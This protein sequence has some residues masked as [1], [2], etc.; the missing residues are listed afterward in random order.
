K[1][2]PLFLLLVLSAPPARAQLIADTLLTWEGYGRISTCRIQIFQSAPDEKRPLTIVLDELQSNEGETTLNDAQHIVELASRRF[3]VDPEGAFWIF[4]WGAFSFAGAAESK[5]EFF[6]RA[7]FRRTDSGAVGP[8]FWRLVN[9][10]TV[11]EYTDRI[12]R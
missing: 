6:F 12:F 1:R 4:H 9:R 8:P 7:T 2:V 11:E 3:V 10:E 5:K